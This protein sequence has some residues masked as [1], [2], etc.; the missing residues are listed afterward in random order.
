MHQQLV[1]FCFFL[2]GFIAPDSFSSFLCAKV[3][4]LDIVTV[5]L[6]AATLIAILLSKFVEQTLDMLLD[7]TVSFPVYELFSEDYSVI[8]VIDS[9]EVLKTS[10]ILRYAIYLLDRNWR[11]T[12]SLTCRSLTTIEMITT[13]ECQS[14]Y[15]V[16]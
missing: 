15:S 13:S 4:Y 12:H 6:P 11:D 1:R 14:T 2:M 3:G 16:S 5:C 7:T 9:G 8:S 10:T